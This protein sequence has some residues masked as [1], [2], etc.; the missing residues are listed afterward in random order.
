MELLGVEFVEGEAAASQ[1]AIDHDAEDA[2]AAG[3]RLG[4]ER[5]VG[6][7]VGDDE[8][9][10][11]AVDDAHA[12]QATK[13]VGHADGAAPVD[14]GFSEELPERSGGATSFEV[15]EAPFWSAGAVPFLDTQLGEFLWCAG[16][17]HVEGEE[18]F[19]TVGERAFVAPIA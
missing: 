13:E 8:A 11:A 16:E 9:H 14:V 17:T 19:A 4:D 18:L 5:W 15:G 7:A 12:G 1:H 10:V 6:A 2:G 3:G